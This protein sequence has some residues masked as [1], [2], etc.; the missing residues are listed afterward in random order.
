M[1]KSR[2]HS[3]ESREVIDETAALGPLPFRLGVN[4]WPARTGMR[5]WTEFDVAELAADFEL[6]KAYGFDSLRIFLTWEAFQPSALHI[7]GTMIARLVST[8][9]AARHAGLSVIPTLFMGHMSG[10]NWIPPWALGNAA[11]DDRFR[12]VSEGRV[13][14]SRLANWFSDDSILR[15][16][17]ALAFALAGALSGH[18]AL[19]AWDLGNENSNC[20]VP[21]NKREGREWLLRM[22]EA[23]RGADPDARVT[24]GLHMEDLSEDRNLGPR[25]AAE[26]C[27]FLTMHG[28]PGYA[29]WADGPTDERALPFLS[30][31]T[32]HL[33][34]GTDVLFAEF[35]VPTPTRAG[36]KRAQTSAAPSH[37]LVDEVA[38]ANYVDRALDALQEAG[39]S[40]LCSGATPT[41]P[42]PSGLFRPSISP[43][44]R[45][46]S[47]SGARTGPRSLHSHELRPSRRSLQIVV[48]TLVLSMRP[49]S[50]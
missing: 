33:S 18:E 13:T 34:G 10:V 42:S 20:V 1:P 36:A 46:P 6:I 4:Y 8:L 27:D 28:Y 5:W 11:G 48:R 35:G 30:R 22:T 31:L 19:W 9:N 21:A 14:G 24:V 12:V 39:A 15:A 43:C 3:L 50:T 37:V 17:Y 29:S 38:A 32:R 49:G 41:T 40:A 45:G 47:V 16:Q 7:D 2:E 44:T 26:C 25:E 23:V